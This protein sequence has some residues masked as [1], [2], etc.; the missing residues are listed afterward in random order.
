VAPSLILPLGY[1]EEP[2][3]LL[4]DDAASKQQK[5]EMLHCPYVEMPMGAEPLCQQ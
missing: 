5:P 1:K 2:V 3:R 4:G